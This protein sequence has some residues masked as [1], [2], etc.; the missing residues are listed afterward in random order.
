MRRL[1]S[2]LIV[3]LVLAGVLAGCSRPSAEQPPKTLV[4]GIS[5]EPDGLFTLIENMRVAGDVM[6]GFLWVR[7]TELDSKGDFAPMLIEELPSLDNGL[8]K[9]K[10]DGTMEVTF[11][12][13]SGLKWADGQP[14]TAR[15]AAFAYELVSDPKFPVKIYFYAPIKEVRVLDERTLLVTYRQP[16]PFAYQ[17]LHVVPEHYYRPIWEEYK[18]RGGEYFKD[19]LNDERVSRKPL[20][21]GAYVVDEWVPGD[22][23]TLKPNPHFSLGPKPQIQRVVFRVIPDVNTLMTNVITGDVHVTDGWLGLSQAQQVLNQAAG[24]VDVR[25]IPVSWFEHCTLSLD[26]PPFDDKRVRQAVLYAIDREKMVNSLFGGKYR[27]ADSWLNE[28]HYAYHPNIKK[29]RYDPD[30][31]RSLLADAGWH[32]GPDGVLV[33]GKGMRFEVDLITIAGDATRQEVAEFIQGE[34][35]KVGIKVNIK[36]ETA[37]VIFSELLPKKGPRPFNGMVMWRWVMRLD[38]M[39]EIW[40]TRNIPSPNLDGWSNEQ[41]DRILAQAQRTMDKEERGALLRQQQ[42]VFAEEVPVIPLYF[43][44]RVATVNKS[45]AGYD[46]SADAYLGWN[47]WSWA[48]VK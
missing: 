14:L 32:P 1:L 7:M 25:F 6:H 41:S 26:K 9:L 22:H 48:W 40:E 8:I 5:Q 15:D 11:K 16:Y 31:A 37:T 43:Y 30:K 45:L 29:Y 19:F 10:E 47:C 2:V 4:I 46:V 33:N 17:G 28:G 39:G 23:I 12:F 44:A 27:V 18:A 42:D 3:G 35:S 34:L 21:N 36:P 13:R 24:S 20:G 38:S